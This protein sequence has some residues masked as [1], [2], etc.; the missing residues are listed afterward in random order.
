[1]LN[2][3]WLWPARVVFE[4]RSARLV[5]LALTP[6]AL[7][8]GTYTWPWGLCAFFVLTA[9]ALAREPS[10]MAA[11]GVGLACA[12]ALLTHPGTLGYVVGLGLWL[13]VRNRSALKW[14]VPAGI[15]GMTALLPWVAFTTR[16]G[17]WGD[18]FSGASAATAGQT[19]MQCLTS[20]QL[21]LLAS[22]LPLRGNPDQS[23][24][25][26][27]GFFAFSLLGS[28]IAVLLVVRP[29][30]TSA[31]RWCVV[32][33]LLGGLLLQPAAE[34][35]AGV[36][37]AGFPAV[38][39]I[40]ALGLAAAS[41]QQ[42]RQVLGLSGMLGLAAVAAL[43]FVTATSGAGDAN[44]ALAQRDHITTLAND[45]PG[46]VAGLLLALGILTGAAGLRRNLAREV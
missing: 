39:V 5:C 16:G 12:G 25:L 21:V 9:V 2:L 15:I 33:G 30:L 18:V 46:V 27:L 36:S 38:V 44:F 42:L 4:G 28:L 20:R 40:A 32:G 45:V 17:S 19:P 1:L 31:A 10:R 34:A 37:D 29:K 13:L 8:L 41:A 43:L 35:G 26:L 24:D 3:V 14:A 7:L 6:M 23:I 22:V 11:L